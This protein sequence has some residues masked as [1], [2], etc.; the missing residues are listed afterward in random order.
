MEPTSQSGELRSV[1]IDPD[2]FSLKMLRDSVS[3]S[4][5]LSL[6]IE[7]W[8]LTLEQSSMS[9]SRQPNKNKMNFYKG[10]SSQCALMYSIRQKFG[11]G[12]DIFTLCLFFYIHCNGNGFC[13]SGLKHCISET[14]S[15]P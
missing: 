14:I 5:L 12:S 13:F 2:T 1:Y 4:Q 8:L 15:S 10:M 6:F 3:D 7:I 9:S 11:P